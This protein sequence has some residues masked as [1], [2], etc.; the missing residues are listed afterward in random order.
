MTT[1]NTS[2]AIVKDLTDRLHATETQARFRQLV[3]EEALLH[4]VR[5]QAVRFVLRDAE[6]VF[7]LKDDALVP[8]HGQTDPSDPLSPLT[9]ALWFQQLAKSDGYLFAQPSRAH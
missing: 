7:T 8:A 5:P 4:G 1:D 6:T 9:P 2:A 3:S